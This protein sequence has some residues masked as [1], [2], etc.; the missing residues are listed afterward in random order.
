M[1]KAAVAAMAAFGLA[2]AA[3][4]ALAK[5]YVDSA[6]RFS[7]ELPDDW[8][9]TERPA[10]G[11]SFVVAGTEF[12]QCQFV[13]TP[14]P[15]TADARPDVM[16]TSTTEPISAEAWQNVMSAMGGLFEGQGVLVSQSVDTSKFWP[17]QRA[18][19][20]APFGP[21]QGAIQFR[22][23]LEIWTFCTTPGN[24]EAGDMFEPVI[25]S[26]GTPQD[27]ALQA[28]AEQL[29]ADADAEYA[30][31]QAQHEAALAEIHRQQAEA[32]ARQAERNRHRRRDN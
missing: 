2:L 6:G 27:A 17:I 25:M 8:P 15:T 12:H 32:E 19:L 3:T 16:R 22:P 18:Q 10:N 29:A 11:F 1:S 14:R 26:V 30:R 4:P 13:A 23:G 7:V 9:V 24:I 21:L 20:R 31:I 28:Q 5:S